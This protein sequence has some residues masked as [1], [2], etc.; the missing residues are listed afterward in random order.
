[1]KVEKLL[2]LLAYFEE[3]LKRAT[4]SQASLKQRKLTYERRCITER[5]AWNTLTDMLFCEVNFSVGTFIETD[6]DALQADFAN[7]FLGV[8]IS[9]T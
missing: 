2:C 1:V 8:N 4:E 3:S 7:K 5:I 6:K 9:P